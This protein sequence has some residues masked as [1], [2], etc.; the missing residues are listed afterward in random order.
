MNPGLTE[1]ALCSPARFV[2]ADT[3][4]HLTDYILTF[5]PV[6]QSRVWAHFSG[7][8]GVIILDPNGLARGGN[9]LAAR[10]NTALE[11]AIG[12]AGLPAY[13][14]AIAARMTSAVQ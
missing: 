14:D 2:A 5:S 4:R 10:L 8:A 6:E 13:A 3:W 1:G 7:A 12:H 11:A 9:Q